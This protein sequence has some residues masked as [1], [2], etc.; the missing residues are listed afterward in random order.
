MRLHHRPLITGFTLVELMVASFI[1]LL[2]ATVAGQIMVNHLETSERA[3]AF[4]RQR[5]NWKRATGFIEA[6]VAL[7]ESIVTDYSKVSIPPSCQVQLSDPQTQFR[8]ALNIRQDVYQSIYAVLP[9]VSGWHG[10]NT[11]WRCGPSFDERGDYLSIEQEDAAKAV[12]DP[13]GPSPQRLVDSLDNQNGTQDG[14]KLLATDS[15]GKLLRFMLSMVL[16]NRDNSARRFSYSN[17]VTTRT[18]ISPLYSRP[19]SGSLCMASNMV[20]FSPT[21][22]QAE[23]GVFA[24][25]IGEGDLIAGQDVL[26]CGK[27]LVDEIRGSS[28]DDII[29][30]GSD[31]ST[32]IVG[33][34]GS[35]VLEG[36]PVT[37]TLK[38]DEGGTSGCPGGDRHD[39]D[40]VLVGNGNS[41]PEAEVFVGGN[42]FN[43]YVP[44][45]GHAQIQGGENLD[46]VF[47]EQSLQK[48]AVGAS[49][50]NYTFAALSGVSSACTRIGCL[51][52]DVTDPDNPKTIILRSVEILIFPD[53]RKDLP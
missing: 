5:E 53:Q 12:G 36:T 18:R 52:T 49:G 26:I 47:F 29:E 3:E 30:S 32:L 28:Y 37:D 20:K 51:V 13:K 6:E 17:T 14:F 8:F 4:Q 33:C 48:T 22:S 46:V 23:S 41:G 15:P 21:T 40:D 34:N 7:S 27:G 19:T 50:E 25:N 10:P 31:Q 44:G 43:R 45:Y 39:G 11:L 35:D 24:V 16:L 1:G 42:G 2:T 9:S 38:G